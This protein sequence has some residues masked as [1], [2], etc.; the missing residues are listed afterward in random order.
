MKREFIMLGG[1]FGLWYI[2]RQVNN[3]LDRLEAEQAEK[4]KEEEERLKVE[5]SK[6]DE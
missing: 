6:S 1:S 4:K 2:A 5:E 3:W